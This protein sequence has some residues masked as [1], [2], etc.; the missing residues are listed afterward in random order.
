MNIKNRLKKLEQQTKHYKNDE[1]PIPDF[2]E[3]TV[4]ELRLLLD[5][6]ENDKEITP[7]ANELLNKAK[8]SI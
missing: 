2:S 4:E 7:E 1:E 5:I 8:W 6:F 3:L